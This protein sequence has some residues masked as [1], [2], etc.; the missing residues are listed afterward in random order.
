MR[1]SGCA[2]STRRS[3]IKNTRLCAYGSAS[4]EATEGCLFVVDLI[5]ICA[6]WTD[7]LQKD[8]AFFKQS[9]EQ[10]IRGEPPSNPYGKLATSCF[11]VVN[12]QP[13]LAV[14]GLTSAQNFSTSFLSRQRDCSTFFRRATPFLAGLFL[15]LR[16]LFFRFRRRLLARLPSFGA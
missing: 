13:V 1:G 12:S 2:I 6:P 5:G 16:S 4:G 9:H 15:R 11:S 3:F 7:N 14:V 8:L 10:E